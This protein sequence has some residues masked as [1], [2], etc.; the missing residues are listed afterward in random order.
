MTWLNI[1]VM[2]INGIGF[3][4]FVTILN[5]I[6]NTKDKHTLYI[7][8]TSQIWFSQGPLTKTQNWQTKT[9]KIKTRTVG[10]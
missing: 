6:L 5:L 4:P 10:W 9:I 3:C 7:I 2:L 8:N 1:A